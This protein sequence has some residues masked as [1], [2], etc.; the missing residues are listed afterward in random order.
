[1]PG[2]KEM[3]QY[4][5][6]SNKVKS[7]SEDF[8]RHLISKLHNGPVSKVSRISACNGYPCLYISKMGFISVM[9]NPDVRIDVTVD[10]TVRIVYFDKF[11]ATLCSDDQTASLAHEHASLYQSDGYVYSIFRTGGA[12]DKQAIVG[13][14]GVIFTL[15]KSEKTYV[16]SK[17]REGPSSVVPIDRPI[18]PP[19][20]RD[21]TTR[22]FMI[23]GELG[24]RM[25][26]L[27][28]EFVSR[29]HFTTI[30]GELNIDVCGIHIRQERNDNIEV[31][32]KLRF[33]RFASMSG[34]VQI[35]TPSLEMTVD[36]EGRGHVVA[37]KKRVHASLTQLVV[38]DD[39]QIATIDNNGKVSVSA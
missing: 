16:M 39:S 29:A 6:N 12:L 35:R 4:C 26:D 36:T 19:L 18:C 5:Y 33:I 24:D 2:F 32:S 13:N 10:R 3:D 20:D 23:N 30:N 11:T 7:E 17:L 34:A 31:S 27:C 37:H 8:C 21:F 25:I 1:M 38:A 9:I 15:G 28:H 22:M 14:E